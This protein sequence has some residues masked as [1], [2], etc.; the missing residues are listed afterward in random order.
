MSPK[1]LI[2]VA[3]PLN[4]INKASAR[5]KSIRQG[6]PSTLHL[7]WARRP[8]ATARAMIF[9]QMVDDPSDLIDEFPT[10]ESQDKE[11]Q[12][13][14]KI[15]EEIVQ[16]EN[17]NNEDLLDKARKEI[18][19]SWRREHPER[20]ENA[21]AAGRTSEGDP[22]ALHDPF[23]GGGTIPLEAQRLGID[24]FASDLNPVSVL[25]NKATIEIPKI[26]SGLTPVNPDASAEVELLERSYVGGQGLAE[27]IRYYGRCVFDE[28]KRRLS[29]LYPRVVISQEFAKGRAELA[30]YIGE[31][32]TV[33]AWIWA[34]TA[35]S[36]NP[37][38][39]DVEVPLAS[40]FCPGSA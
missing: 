5:E 25:I 21:G 24:S 39:A 17:I 4:A 1:K 38:F 22:P 8:L 11:R 29:T 3:I 40:S 36:P 16:W 33:V 12:R 18:L 7:W 26:F 15:I 27:D 19:R 13:L 14:F 9:A 37:A 31:E 28:A 32:L 6:H 23:A 2:E 35:K 34:R 30:H 10:I 20:S